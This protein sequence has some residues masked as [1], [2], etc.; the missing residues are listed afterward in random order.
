MCDANQSQLRYLCCTLLQFEAVSGLRISLG[1]SEM[2]LVGKV[3]TWK[4]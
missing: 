1:K 3:Q 4:I 2:V